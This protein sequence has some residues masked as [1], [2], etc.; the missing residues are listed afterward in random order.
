MA[1][2]TSTIPLMFRFLRKLPFFI[3]LLHWEYWNSRIVYAPLYPYWIWLSLKARSFFFLTAANPCI[4]NGGF[5]MESKMSVQAQVPKHF[6]PTT[7]LVAPK[8]S[9][10]HLQQEMHL[11]GLTFPVIAKP[12]HGERGLAVKKILDLDM[13][14]DYASR[15]P[16]SFLVQEFVAY[17]C[18]IGVFFVRLP[19]ESVGRITGIVAKHPVSITG[20]GK[21]T[22]IEL[23]FQNPRYILQW[24]FI[25]KEYAARLNEVLPKG[26]ALEL[27][28]YGNHSRGSLFTDETYRLNAELE[29][30]LVALCNTIPDFH[31][32]RLDIRF[33]DWSSLKQ[34]KHFSVIEVNGSGSE[35]THIYDPS[36]SLFYA[37]REIAKHWRWLYHISTNQV[38][39]GV[40][41]LTLRQ[42][43][44]EI[45]AFRRIE[46]VLTAA[47]W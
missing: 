4:R 25:K 37:W 15:M 1:T 10:T 46:K 11:N 26:K 24:P 39:R 47:H 23:V 3:R 7:I 21:H 43:R 28:P 6:S 20:D 30:T 45:A 22:I 18:E 32:G 8:C 17:Q 14:V 2:Q 13:L 12:D 19:G 41:P 29:A 9:Q 27:V 31:F 35:P 36:H 42:G 33:K 40:Q 5:V 44:Q 34:G 16:V 38:L